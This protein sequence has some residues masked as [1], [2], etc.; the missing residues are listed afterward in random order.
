MT[1]KRRP[2]LPVR[3]ALGS[4]DVT[5]GG[6]LLRRL[7][8]TNITKRSRI[9]GTSGLLL[10]AMLLYALNLRAPFIAVAPIVDT[11]ADGLGVT[12]ETVGLLT[13]IPVLCFAFFSPV[14][15]L[16][17]S[18][19]GIEQ[20]ITVSLATVFVGT[21][22][23]SSGNFQMA[24]VGTIII[25]AAITIGNVCV[26]V[27][28]SRDFAQSAGIVTGLYTAALN[29]GSVLT[30]II[31]APLAEAVGWRW[32]LAAWTVVMVA[33]AV[34]WR[35]A[36]AQRRGAPVPLVGVHSGDEPVLGSIW[37]RPV[38]WFIALAFAGQSFS[39][40]AVTTWLP[41]ILGDELNMSDSGAGGA[42]SIFQL[43][44]VLG[45]VGIPLLLTRRAPLKAV[46]VITTTLW[47]TLPVGLLVAPELWPLWAACAGTAQGGN[48]T[49][50]FTLIVHHSRAQSEARRMS[51][52]VQTIGYSAAA[53]GPFI[54]GAIHTQSG[55][56]TAPL[57]VMVCSLAVMA[58]SG[59][60]AATRRVPVARDEALTA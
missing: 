51:A 20:A 26:P 37:R 4:L 55:G 56:W 40:Y 25:G 43:F 23:R 14:A 24:V 54:V 29:V 22:I 12:P 50:L 30:T 13:G 16:L 18:R 36:T 32:A 60:L 17:A 58:T 15:S 44:G 33:A 19:I 3:K 34:V 8:R 46:F 6:L 2:V 49:I 5:C 38:A 47:L 59:V 7:R 48:F 9:Y 21:C 39:Y 45:G 52:M 35:K 10:A 28:I 11:I 41:S 27:L 1:P 53:V 57:L 42:A 31:T